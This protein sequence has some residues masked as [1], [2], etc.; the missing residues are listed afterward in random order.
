MN[1]M[2]RT[3][4]LPWLGEGGRQPGAG[5]GLGQRALTPVSLASWDRWQLS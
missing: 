5:S 3:A 1:F 4:Q 2:N